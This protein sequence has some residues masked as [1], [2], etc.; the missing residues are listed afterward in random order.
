VRRSVRAW[1]SPDAGLAALAPAAET[2]ASLL[3]WDAARV[4]AEIANCRTIYEH[5]RAALVAA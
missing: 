2:M 4:A 1:F 3:G 5:S